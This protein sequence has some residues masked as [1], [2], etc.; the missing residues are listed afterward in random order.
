[1]ILHL[2]KRNIASDALV[3]RVGQIVSFAAAVVIPLLVFRQWLPEK[4]LS[5]TELLLVVLTTMSIALLCAVMGE[6]IGAKAKA[7]P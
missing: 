7:P 3:A 4:D 5:E 1:M 6:A 2:L